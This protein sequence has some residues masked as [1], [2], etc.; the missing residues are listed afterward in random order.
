M[1]TQEGRS[2]R[3]SG[4]RRTV[5]TRGNTSSTNWSWNR[6]AAAYTHSWT[7]STFVRSILKKLS[8]TR[9]RLA[10]SGH[11]P[12]HISDLDSSREG[13]ARKRVSAELRQRRVFT[14]HAYISVCKFETLSQQLETQGEKIRGKKT[15]NRS[16]NLLVARGATKNSTQKSHYAWMGRIT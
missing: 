8:R 5:H 2:K 16:C 13:A 4:K 10:F 12:V 6:F 9:K 1:R 11:Y 14:C 3:T 7:C 15:P